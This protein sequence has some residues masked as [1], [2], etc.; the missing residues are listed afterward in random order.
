MDRR[1]FISQAGALGVGASL[2]SLGLLGSRVSAASGDYKALVCVFLFGGNDGN[3]TLV[4]VD[5]AG[6]A[7]YASVRGALALPQSALVPLTESGGAV[8]YAL[9]PELAGWQSLWQSGS[10][11]MLL[12]VGTLQQPLTQAGYNSNTTLKPE[13][14]FSHADQQ[15]QWQASISSAP[16]RTGWGGRLAEQVGGLN[17]GNALPALIS[18]TGP[19]LFVTG[20][21]TSAVTVPVSGK[22]GLNGF[23]SSA[24][25]SARMSALTELLG[26][27]QSSDLVAAAGGIDS[28]AIA[29]SAQLGPVLSAT[30]SVSE[31]SF[32]GLTTNIALQFLAVSKLIEARATF[33]LARQVFM[34]S[35]GSFDTHTAQLERQSNLFAQLAPAVLAFNDALQNMGAADQV[36]TFTLSDFARTMQPNT[37]GGTD[38]AWGNHQFIVGGAVKGGTFYGTYPTL[39]L[40]GPDDVGDEGRW[41]P[42][43]A[44]DQYAATLATW[45]GATSSQL[46][47]VL[48]NLGSFT[49][50]DLGFMKAG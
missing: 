36:T 26:D 21:T 45:F 18:A 2:A 22:F 33:G 42:T 38:H 13:A 7:N 14:L 12:N 32:A 1:K 19:E 8:R 11:A 6:Y 50:S 3:N 16:S 39:Q 23:D 40:G 20:S 27:S 48:P 35:L 34:V 5:T 46:A 47:T 28:S 37:S 44:V 9:H 10:L 24:A 43:I 25:S 41:I 17:G 49:T 15:A 31:T 4:P 30:N 29:T